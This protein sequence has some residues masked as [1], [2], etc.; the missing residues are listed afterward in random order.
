MERSRRRI[1]GPVYI[2]KGAEIQDYSVVTG[3]TFIG[4]NSRVGYHSSIR[5]CVLGENVQIGQR[6]DLTRTIILDR[7]MLSH[8]NTVADSFIGQECWLAGKTDVANLRVNKLPVKATIG[9]R[10]YPTHGKYGAT[11][12]DGVKFPALITMMPGSYV[13]KKL[14]MQIRDLISGNKV[15]KRR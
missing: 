1:T 2:C 12:E 5:S 4:A 14:R 8:G 6:I 9:D 3:P 7:S 10:R 13:S 15:H 11:I